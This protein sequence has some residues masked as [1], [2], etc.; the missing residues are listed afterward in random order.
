MTRIYDQEA[1]EMENNAYAFIGWSGQ[2]ISR[3][4]I[5]WA[6]DLPPAEAVH[7]DE[8]AVEGDKNLYLRNTAVPPRGM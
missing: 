8:P 4:E 3:F 7:L 5:P 2:E 1:S 6:S